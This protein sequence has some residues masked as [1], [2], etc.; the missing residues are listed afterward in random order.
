[1]RFANPPEICLI[2]WLADY[3]LMDVECN[4][5]GCEGVCQLVA[6]G[7]SLGLKCLSEVCGFISKGGRRGFWSKGQMLLG[8]TMAMVYS[9]VMGESFKTAKTYAGLDISKNTWTKYSKDIG[10]VLEKGWK[11]IEGMN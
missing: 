6:L 8:T 10:L 1:M 9:I 2:H 5:A 11:E 7:N 4:H 3:K